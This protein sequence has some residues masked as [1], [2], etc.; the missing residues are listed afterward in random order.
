LEAETLHGVGVMALS[1]LDAG[2]LLA[3][4]TATR[5]TD[6][7]WSQTQRAWSSVDDWVIR[8]HPGGDSSADLFKFQYDV[9]LDESVRNLK[10]LSLLVLVGWF[11]LASARRH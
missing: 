6:L 2:M 7:V 11:A 4:R 8:F 1:G 5:L 10:E 3:P 9:E